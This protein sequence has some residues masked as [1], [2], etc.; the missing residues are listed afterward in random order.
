MRSDSCR[1]RERRSIW[2][3]GGASAAIDSRVA[4][5]PLISQPV[6]AMLALLFHGNQGGVH[7]LAE[8]ETG[9]LW[10]D[11]A[12]ESQF[13]CRTRPAVPQRNQN[14][15]ARRFSHQ[16]G[17][18][19]NIR[20]QI[21]AAMVSQQLENSSIPIESSTAFILYSAVRSPKS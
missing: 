12:D 11:V 14:C 15:R 7:Q 21:H 2:L 20:S 19:S 16:P 9:R 13:P 18:H 8:V 3:C 1:V 17:D 5:T 4:A 10:R 6:I